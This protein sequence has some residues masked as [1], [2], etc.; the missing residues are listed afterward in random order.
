MG[1]LRVTCAAAAVCARIFWT[2]SP[3]ALGA[4]SAAD[5]P[6]AHSSSFLA[7]A[8]YLDGS[9]S[10]ACENEEQTVSRLRE[11]V[12]RLLVALLAT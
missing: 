7:S 12:H 4:R 5:L 2:S 8:R 1:E 3:S 6:P 11:W 10:R 9:S